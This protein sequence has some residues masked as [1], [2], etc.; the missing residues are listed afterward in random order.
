VLLIITQFFEKIS[1]GISLEWVHV[2]ACG[3]VLEKKQILL[4]GNKWFGLIEQPLATQLCQ[5]N[6]APKCPAKNFIGNWRALYMH[7]LP[8]LESQTGIIHISNKILLG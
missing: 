2:Q 5:C 1:C 8:S 7:K 3:T 6:Q 4:P